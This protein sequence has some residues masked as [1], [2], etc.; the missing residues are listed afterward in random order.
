[1]NYQGQKLRSN[2]LLK[3]C[4]LCGQL[5]H[6]FSFT[7][8]TSMRKIRFSFTHPD[9]NRQMSNTQAHL[10]L[11]KAHL[12]DRTGRKEGKLRC[13]HIKSRRD[14]SRQRS[15]LARQVT[16]AAVAP[17]RAVRVAAVRVAATPVARRFLPRER[18]SLATGVAATFNVAT[19]IA[20]L[21]FECIFRCRFDHS[22]S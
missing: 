15:S 5:V 17:G 2:T 9:L 1:M 14:S 16:S 20:S 7:S 6:L 3:S 13:G 18:R 11:C 19:P 10:S 21:L 4:L 12:V 22:T 8:D